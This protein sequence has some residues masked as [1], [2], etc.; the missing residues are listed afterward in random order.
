M[1]PDL[2]HTSEPASRAT[3]W[4]WLVDTLSVL[5][6]G[7]IMIVMLVMDADVIGRAVW[8]RPLAGVA[9]I[10][11]MSIAAI[12]FLQLPAALAAGRFVRSDV[13]LESLRPR[14]PAAVAW[15]QGLWNAL[16]ALTFALL[17]HAAAPLVWKD[18][19]RGE[20]YGSPG[21]FTFP[22]WPV[23]VIV[24]L[25]CAATAVQFAIMAW[26]DVRA[27]RAPQADGVAGAGPKP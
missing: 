11:T 7:L 15:I 3:P 13:L 17:C 19:M 14:H 16:G 5:G 4:A 21:V 18:W 8:N 12:V 9:E 10:V 27:A 1:S 2:P 25:G 24:L 6:T 26:R 23:G 22:R 20:V